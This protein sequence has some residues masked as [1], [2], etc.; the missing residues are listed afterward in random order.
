MASAWLIRRFIDRDAEFAFVSDL[1]AAPDGAVPFD[2]YDVEFTHQGEQC[3]FEV[4]CDRFDLTSPALSRVAAIVH[5]LDLKDAR[6]RP[7]E[8]PAIGALIDGLQLAQTDDHVLLSSG[9]SMF[10]ALY[11]TFARQEQPGRPRPVARRSSSGARVSQ[12]RQRT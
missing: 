7:D 3:T 1:A 5:D 8:A 9:M 6:Y 4:L 11:L 10:E 2:M 12:K